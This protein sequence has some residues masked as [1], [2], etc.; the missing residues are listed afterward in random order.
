M[1]TAFFLLKD[2]VFAYL[3]YV[4]LRN[5][6][7]GKGMDINQY[8]KHIAIQDA[9]E[10]RKYFH[11][12]ACIRWH[13]TKEQ[14]NVEEF[15]LAN[16]DYP[17]N[18]QGQVVRI[19]CKENQIITV[20]RIW[21]EMSSFHVISFFEIEEDKIKVLDEYWCEDGEVPQWRKE[22]NIGIKIE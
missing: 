20:T 10:L 2:I 12:E 18:W 14:F 17:G 19:E 6:E 5:N 1:K 16:C 22:K 21:S 13:D 15:L 11:K 7:G 8:W 3:V 4:K 9:E